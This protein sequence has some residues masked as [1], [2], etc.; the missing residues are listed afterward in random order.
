MYDPKEEQL[1]NLSLRDC[2]KAIS[3]FR[4]LVFTK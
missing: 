3:S 1:K 4:S 2:F